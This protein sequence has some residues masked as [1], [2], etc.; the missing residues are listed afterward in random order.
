MCNQDSRSEQNQSSA[1]TSRIGNLLGTGDSYASAIWCVIGGCVV[2]AGA[3]FSDQAELISRSKN[4]I[5]AQAKSPSTSYRISNVVVIHHTYIRALEG[6]PILY[7]AGVV[8]KSRCIQWA[9]PNTGLAK[10]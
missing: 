2:E 1:S 6:A 7:S 3:D 4:L 8:I 5:N 9:C 10:Q